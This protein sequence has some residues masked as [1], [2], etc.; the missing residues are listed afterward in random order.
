MHKINR[1]LLGFERMV[2]MAFARTFLEFNVRFEQPLP[3]GAKIFAPNHPTTTDPFLMSLVTQEP[4]I[5]LVNKRIFKLPLVGKLIE[6][7][8]TIPV[9]KDGGEGEVIITQTANLLSTGIPV[10]IFP[11]GRLSPDVTSL[12]RLHT[13][14]TRIALKADCPV[15][16]VGIYLHKHSIKSHY[17]HKQYRLDESRWILHGKYYITVGE[18]LYFKGDVNDHILVQQFTQQLSEE[19]QRLMLISEARA[20]QKSIA[21]NPIIPL[22]ARS[23][24]R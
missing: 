11:E 23:M 10:A 16:P 18:P 14:V 6:K 15:I 21:W 19:M 22:F 12:A 20:N 17:F 2:M 1:F 7:A 3:G 5:I 4:L 9:D 24:N 13:G 8:G